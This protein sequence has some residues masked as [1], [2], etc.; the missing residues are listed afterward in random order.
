LIKILSKKGDV[1]N[2]MF[3]YLLNIFYLL[4]LVRSTS[5][6]LDLLLC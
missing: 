3:K 1:S 5:M 6:L 4:K 2:M